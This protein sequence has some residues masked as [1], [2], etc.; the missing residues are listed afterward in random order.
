MNTLFRIFN[1]LLVVGILSVL[2]LIFQGLPREPIAVVEPV[3]VTG[4]GSGI[5]GSARIR[6]PVPVSVTI[7][8]TP[9]E[10]EISR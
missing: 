5:R 10:V 4:S 7:D 8:N 2:I 3:E 1:T 9:L 6:G